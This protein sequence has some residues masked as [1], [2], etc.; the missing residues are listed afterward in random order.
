[1]KRKLA[2]D[3]ERYER[4]V[5]TKKRTMADIVKLE[6]END[7]LISE[8]MQLKKECEWLKDEN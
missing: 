2:S 3:M 4:K 5:E 1:M 6:R 7:H 8:N